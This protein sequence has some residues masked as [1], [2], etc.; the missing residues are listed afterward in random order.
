MLGGTVG[1]IIG[2]VVL[3]LIVLLI[4]YLV[5]RRSRSRRQEER[6]ERTREEFGS[7]YERTTRE[8]GSEQEAE[9]E[10]RQRRG[11]MERQVRPLSDEDRN[12]Y[13][14]RWREVESLFVDNPTRSV[15]MAD[16]TVSDLLGERNFVSDPAQ[17]EEE[18]HKS[19]GALHP[20]VADDYREARRIR[21]VVVGRSAG[22]PDEGESGGAAGAEATEEMR[23]AVRYYRVVYEKLVE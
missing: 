23:E 4:V 17:N 10:L 2:L 16:R 13:G 3:V 7:E 15:E 9:K 1:I 12:R 18:T 19:L 20:D 22:S 11:R 6:Q 14:E 5:S 21:A 8:R